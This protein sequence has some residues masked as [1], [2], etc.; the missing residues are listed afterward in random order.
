MTQLL[1]AALELRLPVQK[2][3]AAQAFCECRQLLSK[4]W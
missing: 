3:L 2:S 1:F 4:L